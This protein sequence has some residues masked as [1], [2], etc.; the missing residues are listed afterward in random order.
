MDIG[1]FVLK[2]SIVWQN[3][4]LPVAYVASVSESGIR[5][6]RKIMLVDFVDGPC[7]YQ[8][9]QGRTF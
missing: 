2:A 4:T 5:G 7:V 3:C 9:L 8:K 1:I 6:L